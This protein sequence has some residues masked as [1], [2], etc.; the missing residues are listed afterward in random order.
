[1]DIE[2]WSIVWLRK[3]GRRKGGGHVHEDVVE[4]NEMNVNGTVDGIEE[5]QGWQGMADEV[6]GAVTR[7]V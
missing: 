4:R 7:G 5:I 1:M 6:A 3:T 2:L